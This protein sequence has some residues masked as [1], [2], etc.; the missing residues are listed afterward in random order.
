MPKVKDLGTVKD[1]LKKTRLDLD[2]N[3]VTAFKTDG[4]LAS[5]PVNAQIVTDAVTALKKA[6]T[7]VALICQQGVLGVKIS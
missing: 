6:E 3:T 5:S 1:L 7:A 4:T 2:G